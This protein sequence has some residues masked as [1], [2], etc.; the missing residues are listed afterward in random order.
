MKN[1]NRQK[2]IANSRFFACAAGAR[3]LQ[4]LRR[5]AVRPTVGGVVARFHSS[6]GCHFHVTPGFAST[7]NLTRCGIFRGKIL[8]R[9]IKN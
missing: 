8:R 4:I 7:N 6:A 2:N 9:K 3:L 5:A 1:L